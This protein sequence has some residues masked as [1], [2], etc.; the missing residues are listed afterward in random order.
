M[1]RTNDQAEVA[2]RRLNI[3][4]DVQHPRLWSFI[5]SI[6]SL[7]AGQDFCYNQLKAGMS[8]PKKHKKYFDADKR[9]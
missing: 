3:E 6:K 4:M 8:Q 5:M 7:Q 1:N 2:N 9:F